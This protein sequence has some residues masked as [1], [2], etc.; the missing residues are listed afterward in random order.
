MRN[1]WG[2]EPDC[3]WSLDAQFG[4]DAQPWLTTGRALLVVGVRRL[5]AYNVLQW[6]RKRHLRRRDAAG[7]LTDPPSWKSLFRWVQQAL[8]LPQDLP[9]R[10][11]PAD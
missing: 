6:A 9:T 1:H 5:M 7:D 4:E 10:P 11:Q 2:I 8:R 3:F